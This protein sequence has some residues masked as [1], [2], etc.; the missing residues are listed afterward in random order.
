[1]PTSMDTR[2]L[3]CQVLSWSTENAFPRDVAPVVEGIVSWYR[4]IQ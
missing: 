2:H 1:M 4:V 3:K